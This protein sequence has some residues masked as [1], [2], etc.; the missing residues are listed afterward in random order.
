M[1]KLIAAVLVIAIVAVLGL[2]ATKPDTLRVQR[3]TSIHAPPEKIY[4]LVQDFHQWPQWSPYEKKDPTMKRTFTDS[5]SGKGA[6]Y[7]WNGNKEVGSG[8][9]EIIEANP[10]GKVGIK[11]YFLEPFEGHN[12]A[13]F[14][15]TPR[16]ENTE[17]TWLM[18][19][20][21]PLLGRVIQVFLNVDDM[22][23][24]DFEAGLANLKTVAER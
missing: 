10:P 14:T 11:L 22:I 6:R 23:G 20:P 1:L 18:Y 13:E 19:G 24:K 4:A 3:S 7:A 17:V 21:N 9:M 8:S 12:T 5:D 16:A 15:M 2:A